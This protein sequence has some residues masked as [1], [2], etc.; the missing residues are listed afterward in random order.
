MAKKNKQKKWTPFEPAVLREDQLAAVPGS[1]AIRNDKVFLNSHYQVNARMIRKPE[2]WP[3]DMIH[4]SIKRI[5][6]HPVHDWRHFQ[7]IKNE[8]V[9]EEHEAIEIYPAESRLVDTSNQYHLWVFAD[10][11]VKL[12][13]GFNGGRLIWEGSQ[14]GSKQR[15][16]PAEKRPADCTR[17]TEGEIARE[18]K[19]RTSEKS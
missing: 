9:G 19:K 10:P 12:P 16:W 1:D 15:D 13:I 3:C 17:P 5:D 4:L 7:W 14:N 11:G 18:V 6:K 2:G 8:L